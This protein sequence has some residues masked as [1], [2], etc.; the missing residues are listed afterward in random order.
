MKFEPC[1]RCK[2][3]PAIVFITKLDK[4]GNKTREGLCAACA[5]ELNIQPFANMIKSFGI[6]PEDLRQAMENGEGGEMISPEMLNSMLAPLS[7]DETPDET[8]D[9]PARAPALS[10]FN[11]FKRA[12]NAPSQ[13]QEEETPDARDKKRRKQAE[14][15]KTLSAF[16]TDLTAK[17]KEGKVDRVVGRETEIQR[18]IQIL[19]RRQ[20]NNPCLIGEPGVGKTAVAEGL[21]KRISDKQVP[22]RLLDKEVWL[23]DMSALV[24]GTQFRGQFEA[25]V[26]KLIDEVNALGNV[27]LVIDEVH[28]LVG[29][30]DAE[31][32]M[33]AA[34]ILKPA[35]SR[36]EIQV[37]GATTFKEYRKY[38]EKDSA[39]ERRF[40]PVVISEPSVDETTEILRGVKIYY[41]TYHGVTVPDSIIAKAVYLADRY[42]SDRFMPDKAID[43]LDEACSALN[44]RSPFIAQIPLL[45][46]ELDERFE[47]QMQMESGEQTESTYEQIAENKSRMMQIEDQLTKLRSLPPPVLTID[48]LAQVIEIWTKIP[49]SRIREDEQKRLIELSDRLKSKIIGQDGACDSIASAIRRRRAGLSD[50]RKPISFIFAGPTGVGKT[51]LVKQLANQLFASDDALIR[52]DMSEYMEQHSV[53]KLIG[54][55]PGYV[56]YEEAGQLTEKL[57]RRP[58]S[59]VLFDEIEKAHHDV[60]N[61]LLQILDE[62]RITDAQGRHVSFENAVIVMTSNAGSDEASGSVGFGT[63]SGSRNKDRT[64]KALK[65][66]MR[67]EFLN[68]VDEIIAFNNLSES[69][70]VDICSLMLNE[71]KLQM[72]KNGLELY[73]SEEAKNL[74]AEK[75]FS[76]TYGARN[77]RRI[78]EKEVEDKAAAIIISRYQNPVKKVTVTAENGEI[79][80]T[81]E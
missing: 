62:G 16:A 17:A 78:I 4:D 47:R 56:G 10:I 28:T 55:P 5:A 48:D 46:A 54:A 15:K 25:R 42:I 24:A 69:N 81:A 49:A 38:I 1:A 76:V 23:L 32:G 2:K 79:K 34:N 61:A 58:Y 45:Q 33:N 74:L 18:V 9:E 19:N 73:W 13:E 65:K 53:S 27:I 52:L 35:L 21:A 77:L 43:L 20:K 7:Q 59:V 41:E 44:L 26:K 50:K 66:I 3:G 39:L 29:T 11:I 68:R 67:P 80:V 30:G 57:R 75:G 64:M 72:D 31:G 12:E 6:T 63:E 60:L 40:Q 37:I 8:P 22:Q 36:G 14:K 71:L 51:E 70:M